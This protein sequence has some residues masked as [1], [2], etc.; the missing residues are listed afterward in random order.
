MKKHLLLLPAVIIAAGATAQPILNMANN[1]F[2]MG[3]EIRM[4][5]ADMTEEGANGAGITWD[6]SSFTS[7]ATTV[8]HMANPATMDGGS[9][10]PEATAAFGTEG[11]PH[12]FY[13]VS[14]S[15]ISFLGTKISEGYTIIYQD[16][17]EVMRYPFTMGTNY[18]DD[19]AADVDAM[20]M[21]F[22]RGG[23]TEVTGTGYGTL[24]TPIGTFENALKVKMVQKYADT[25]E[26]IP[27]INYHYELFQWHVPGYHYPV[28]AVTKVL[29]PPA[30]T[31]SMFIESTPTSAGDV[32]ALEN[33]IDFYPNPAT[34][35]IHVKSLGKRELER[36]FISDISGKVLF[37]F[38]KNIPEAINVKELP[39]G[40]YI[41]NIVTK[42]GI[43][44][45]E[46]FA[47]K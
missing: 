24:I 47:K 40:N 4:N 38:N 3:E 19:F 26:G 35:L 18:T 14:S 7:G 6:F 42:D 33:I 1:G 22:K 34:D 9:L 25:L 15:G 37:D 8:Y 39:A 10:F 27:M 5:T 23:T 11:A 44:A 29:A 12:L 43:K 16:P 32:V 17:E 20:G 13:K 30:S 46:L 36:L 21:V 2:I 45:G 41:I 31:V 28:A